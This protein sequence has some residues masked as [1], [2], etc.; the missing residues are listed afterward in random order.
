MTDH[1]D[2]LTSVDPVAFEGDEVLMKMANA[3]LARIA[4]QRQRQAQ[5]LSRINIK[6]SNIRDDVRSMKSTLSRMEARLELKLISRLESKFDE[7]I[8]DNFELKMGMENILQL[9]LKHHSAPNSDN[10]RRSE[11]TSTSQLVLLET[12][13]VNLHS[14]E[15]GNH[16]DELGEGSSAE[17]AINGVSK[18][19]SM[20]KLSNGLK[21]KRANVAPEKAPIVLGSNAGC[22]TDLMD[23]Y[24]I[25]KSNTWQKSER[26]RK[27][28]SSRKILYQY[29]EDKGEM[30]DDENKT[31][32]VVEKYR[33]FH[34]YTVRALAKLF[35]SWSDMKNAV[36][37]RGHAKD[38]YTELTKQRI[39]EEL[40]QFVN[41]PLCYRS[42][43]TSDKSDATKAQNQP[44]LG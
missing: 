36:V 19:T 41:S 18:D 17:H 37:P 21:R 15:V 33:S 38:L 16:S 35:E 7:M 28:L 14:Q 1:L 13:L 23:E 40:R 44:N 42:G 22:I 2:R 5:L 43:W 31:V 39:D 29:I 32:I 30:F 11:S 34:R 24:K 6:E 27:Y 20:T 25:V 8:A 12:L 10:Q 3:F 26:E 9:L 4:E